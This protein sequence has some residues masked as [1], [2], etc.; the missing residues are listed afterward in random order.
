MPMNRVDFAPPAAPLDVAGLGPAE[1]MA[2]NSSDAAWQGAAF[3]P[4]PARQF[5]VILDGHGAVT[6]SDGERRSG[7]PGMRFLLEDATGKGA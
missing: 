2:V 1:S 5:L 3:H 6:A 4:P 7:G